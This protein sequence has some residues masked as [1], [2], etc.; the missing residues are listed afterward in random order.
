VAKIGAADI[1]VVVDE[2][3]RRATPGLKRKR[4]LVGLLWLVRR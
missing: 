3:I 1:K 2:T 4:A